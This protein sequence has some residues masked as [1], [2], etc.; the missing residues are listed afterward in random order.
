MNNNKDKCLY[1]SSMYYLTNILGRDDENEGTKAIAKRIS[2]LSD[3]EVDIIRIQLKEETFG[4]IKYFTE[5]VGDILKLSNM[6]IDIFLEKWM[7]IYGTGTIFALELYP[8]F[9]TLITDAYVGCYINNQKSIE[10]I[11]GRNM[12]D[13]T[14]TVL[15]IGDEAV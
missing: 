10:K 13:F 3:R 8:S 2:G 15:R 12:V 9:T 4:N 5:S 6:K 14:K 11:A 7:Y 1:L